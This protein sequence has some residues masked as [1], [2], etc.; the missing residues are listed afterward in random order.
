MPVG[1]SEKRTM[2][3]KGGLLDEVAGRGA[4][5]EPAGEGALAPGDGGAN[6]MAGV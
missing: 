4:G 5:D 3:E 2:Q 1:R 6:K